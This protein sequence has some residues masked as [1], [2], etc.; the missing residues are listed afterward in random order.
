[1]R[2]SGHVTRHG[3]P[4]C[5]YLTIMPELFPNTR[6]ASLTSHARLKGEKTSRPNALNLHRCGLTGR[7]HSGYCINVFLVVVQQR[8]CPAESIHVLSYTRQPLCSCSDRVNGNGQ[9]RLR[10]YSSMSNVRDL[11]H[12][13]AR[14]GGFVLV[15][16]SV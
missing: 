11:K 14:C 4:N 10:R 15:P 9:H 2:F 16:T 1:M 8:T 7:H 3:A 6:T 13:S 12:R 5:D